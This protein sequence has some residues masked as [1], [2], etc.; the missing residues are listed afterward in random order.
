[1]VM[2]IGASQQSLP[3][4]TTADSLTATSP[5][6]AEISTAQILI[7]LMV[8]GLGFL[9]DVY[10]IV[11]FAVVRVSSLV[12]LGVAQQDS[13]ST[14]VWLLNLQMA[15]MLVG[16]FLWGILGD[17]KGRKSVLFGSIVL[18]SL[19]NIL[20]GFVTDVSQYAFLRFLAG[21]GLAGE[22]GAAMTIAAEVT[23][24][25]YRA[26]GTAAVAGI[27]VFGSI[28]ASLVG[29]ALS[30]RMAFITA[31]IAGIFLLFARVSLKE[32]P[33]Y[34]KISQDD[35][36]ERGSIK[37]LFLDKDRVLRLVRCVLAAM[38]LWFVLGVI[39]SFAPEIRGGGVGN[40]VI[41]VAAVALFYS[42]GETVGEVASCVLS[43][44]LR[45]RKL[46]MLVFAVGAFISLM[47]VLFGPPQFYGAFCLPLGF[48]VGSWSVVVTSAAEQFGTNLRATATTLVPNLVRASV[49][50][51]TTLFGI[52]AA[53]FGPIFAAMATGGLCLV[54]AVASILLMEETYGKDMDFVER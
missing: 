52:L 33:L 51:V 48:F 4:A 39:V 8:A 28:L 45:S 44:I 5:V 19:A 41:S 7:A 43:Q 10:D 26:Y 47:C 22:V 36:L 53:T 1:M 15:G 25:K 38:P 13:L 3:Q 27:G 17:K 12:S 14:G 24:R 29:G 49:I 2:N 37:L 35:K 18:Y 40:I 50:P 34:A 21:V 16:G 6:A 11:I 30:W 23:P 31:G 42:I 9:V 46:A 20:N 54:C 32:T